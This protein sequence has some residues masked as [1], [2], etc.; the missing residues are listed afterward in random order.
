[1]PRQPQPTIAEM[2]EIAS[3]YAESR[4]VSVRALGQEYRVGRKTMADWIRDANIDVPP[5]GYPLETTKA[6][7][8]DYRKNNASIRELVER[9]GGNRNLLMDNGVRLRTRGQNDVRKQRHQRARSRTDAHQA[10]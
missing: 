6:I 1:M 7:V 5:H 3:R 8:H 2:A 9:Y 10:E 4:P